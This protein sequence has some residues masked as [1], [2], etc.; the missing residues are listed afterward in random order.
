MNYSE[1]VEGFEVVIAVLLEKMFI[2]ELFA[3]IYVDTFLELCAAVIVLAVKARAYYEA[4][5][6]YVLCG[7]FVLC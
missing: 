7:D 5:G 6:T 2:C 3:G 1:L 4:R